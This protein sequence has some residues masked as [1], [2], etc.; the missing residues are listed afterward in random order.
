M[1]RNSLIALSVFS[2]FVLGC[3]EK[4]T[5]STPTGDI[6]MTQKGDA[7]T[8][9]MKDKGEKT[10]VVISGNDKGV[11]LPDKFPS[12]FPIMPGAIVKVAMTMGEDMNVQFSVKASQADTV[13]YYEEN[14]KAK[15]WKIEASMNTGASSMMSA[16]KGNRECVLNLV[17]DK[18]GSIVQVM[19]ASEKS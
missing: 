9:E 15:G 10:N 8:F 19:V 5:V 14:L 4:T 18:E 7:I 2:L 3:G 1:K 12:D 13:K 6:K 11:A 16:K 17:T